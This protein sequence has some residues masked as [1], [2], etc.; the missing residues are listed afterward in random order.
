[1]NSTASNALMMTSRSI[2]PL[3]LAVRNF[4]FI[5]PQEATAEDHALIFTIASSM[6][7][8][9]YVYISSAEQ[10]T[11][12]DKGQIRYLP[13]RGG[14]FPSFGSVNAVFV[15]RDREI[16][17][18]ALAEYQGVETFLLEPNGQVQT[19]TAPAHARPRQN[20]GALISFPA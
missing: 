14:Q 15:L 3:P 7:G 9:G 12:E 17:T 8:M 4:L 10:T 13:F 1:M 5:L 20:I 2:A 11:M 16:A 19:S 18:A 6:T